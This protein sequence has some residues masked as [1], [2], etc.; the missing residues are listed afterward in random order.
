M[1]HMRQKAI[2]TISILQ[3]PQSARASTWAKKI[4]SH[5]KRRYPD[6]HI[7][8]P[9]TCPDAVIALG[10]DATI[11]HAAKLC[12]SKQ[13]RVLGLNVG[14]LGFLAAERDSKHFLSAVDA[15]LTLKA[16][17]EKR[18]TLTAR[19]VRAQK[20]IATWDIMNDI[21]VHNPL[22][23][24]SL[25]I[26]I[27]GQRIQTI[28]GSGALIAT[29]SGSTAYNLSAHGPIVAPEMPCMIITE[30]LDHNTPTPSVVIEHTHTASIQIT[31]FRVR[32]ALTLAGTKELANVVAIGDGSELV[33]LQKEDTIEVTRGTYPVLFAH[34]RE[35]HFFRTLHDAFSFR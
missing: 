24:V 25:D 28:R 13:T 29:A 11:M 27:D 15:L 16:H 35:H 21:V 23:M 17:I 8:E 18:Y 26:Y 2:R 31:D 3:R 34:T 32:H 4:R 14:T 20:T 7:G 33:S 19:V 9:R 6:I 12:R 5:I 22:G 10:G 1:L 30:L